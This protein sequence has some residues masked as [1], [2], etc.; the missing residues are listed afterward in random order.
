V[1]EDILFHLISSNITN[2]LLILVSLAGNIHSRTAKQPVESFSMFDM[3]HYGKHFTHIILL[4]ICSVS[5]S[6]FH[7]SD[8]GKCFVFREGKPAGRRYQYTAFGVDH[9]FVINAKNV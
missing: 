1:T 9:R 3:L 6:I 7:K 5:S 2:C 4:C 8:D